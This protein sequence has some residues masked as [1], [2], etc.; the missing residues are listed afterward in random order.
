M[1][2]QNENNSIN[3]EQVENGFIVTIVI[4]QNQE[5]NPMDIVNNFLPA[6]E[7][8]QNKLTG[9][10]WKNNIDSDINDALKSEPIKP[11]RQF[12]CKT[13]DEVLEIINKA[14]F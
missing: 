7:K 13:W 4:V 12:V 8:L 2:R 9:D 6:F 14:N 1:Y 11:I 5:S 10:D 3:I